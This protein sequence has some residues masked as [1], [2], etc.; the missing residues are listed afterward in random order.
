MTWKG[1]EAG[2]NESN[3]GKSEAAVVG[4]RRNEGERGE[5]PKGRPSNECLR[6]APPAQGAL[7]LGPSKEEPNLD[8]ERG[9]VG[10]Q[11]ATIMLRW[12]L[13]FIRGKS[14][15]RELGTKKAFV[16]EIQ[17]GGLGKASGRAQWTRQSGQKEKKA[18]QGEDCS[19]IIMQ[20][21]RRV[22]TSRE[23]KTAA[24]GVGH[25]PRG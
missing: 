23:K 7:L 18:Q 13:V 17:E 20:Q 15:R 5:I 8:N 24:E 19:R 2:L 16:L 21:K 6:C 11:L 3:R 4:G 14:L 1:K 25:G 12:G 22:K 9:P 10:K